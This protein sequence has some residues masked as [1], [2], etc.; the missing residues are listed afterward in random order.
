MSRA[1]PD[2]LVSLGI[3]KDYA[4]K[5]KI[6]K[7]QGCKECDGVGSKGRIAIHEVLRMTSLLYNAIVKKRNSS[8]T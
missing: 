1:T 4:H 5:V 2:Y 7:G 3:R 6:Y 8:R